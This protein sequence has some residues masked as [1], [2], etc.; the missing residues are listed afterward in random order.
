M[1]SKNKSLAAI[2]REITRQK[3]SLN[4]IQAVGSEGLLCAIS[5]RRSLCHDCRIGRE[6]PVQHPPEGVL[7]RLRHLIKVFRPFGLRFQS[8]GSGNDLRAGFAAIY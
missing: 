5:R 6:L 3:K 4:E 2:K 8:D 7:L 1:M